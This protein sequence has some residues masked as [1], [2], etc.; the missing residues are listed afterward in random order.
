[1]LPHCTFRDPLPT[2]MSA[3]GPIILQAL[4]LT[5]G[6]R[7]FSALEG[8]NL[9]V[10]Q[11]TIHALIGPNGAG[12]TT[13]FNLLTRF[14]T[15]DSGQILYRGQDITRRPP[16]WVARQG[17]VR[18][19]QISAVFPHLSVLENVCVALQ[20]RLGNSFHFWKSGRSLRALETRALELLHQV[21]LEH[22]EK[23]LAVALPYGQKRAL[24]IATTLALD[25]E[26]LLLDE[27]T[28]GMGQE[29][30]VQIMGLIQ[31][32]AAQR[33]VLMVEHNMKVVS[34]ICDRITVLARGRVLAEGSYAEMARHP[35]VISAYMGTEPLY[36]ARAGT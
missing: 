25:P 1:M 5:K 4:Q 15:A 8:I 16:A 32:V 20:R 2:H 31:Q 9:T 12:K 34:A 29:D 35:E 17:L 6:F 7:G 3:A 21:G 24:E 33:T 30:V 14:I 28:Q 11:G 23:R 27:P 10:R 36:P 19:F 18:S 22:Q 26:L 13:C